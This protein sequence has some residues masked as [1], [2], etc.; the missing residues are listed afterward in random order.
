MTPDIR[1]LFFALGDLDG[2]LNRPQTGLMR[3]AGISLD[4]ALLLLLIRIEHRGP[5]GIVELAELSGRDYNTVSRQVTKLES[6]GL[7]SRRIG[8]VD[9]RVREVVMTPA[10]LAMTG[11]A[12]LAR[13]KL[14][15]AIR[16]TWSPGEIQELARL[17]RR[18]ADAITR[19]DPSQL[20]TQGSGDPS[21]ETAP[22]RAPRRQRSIAG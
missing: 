4:R 10:G 8:A 2:I 5:T 13:E 21:G 6:L 17:S 9:R 19:V 11:A 20:G 15:A 16:A 22:P 18:L 3:E 12:D 14:L 1:D 7:A